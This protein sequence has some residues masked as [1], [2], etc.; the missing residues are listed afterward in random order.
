MA[1]ILRWCGVTASHY[2]EKTPKRKARPIHVRFQTI[3][4]VKRFD[5]HRHRN[6]T[7][8]YC[9]YSVWPFDFTDG[10]S[11]SEHNGDEITALKAGKIQ[12]RWL[13]KLKVRCSDW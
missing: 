5:R 4:A 8:D 13:V 6:R 10:G 3:L 9:R 2:R 1:E 12:C 7:G 11:E